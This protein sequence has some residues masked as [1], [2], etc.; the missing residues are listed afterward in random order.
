LESFHV[1]YSRYHSLL[2]GVAQ[3]RLV[4]MSS[5]ED[6][7]AEAFA[8]AW[9]HYREGGEL[10]LPWLYQVLRNL[11]GNE[12]QRAVRADKLVERVGASLGT[13]IVEF[14]TDD[15]IG[16]RSAI[17]ELPEDDRELIYMAY[18]EDLKRNEMAAILGC[19][20][21]A[22]RLRLMRAKRRLKTLVDGSET[23]SKKEGANG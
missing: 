3:Q 1:F 20:A 17:K 9:S 15:A 16:L 23:G 19:S 22:V 4:G 8:I 18:W 5:A 6:V 7:V 10:T 21:T 13:N 14:A 2:L 11:I 12:Y